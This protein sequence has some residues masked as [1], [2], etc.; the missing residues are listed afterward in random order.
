MGCGL[1]A[2]SGASGGR[3]CGDSRPWTGSWGGDRPRDSGLRPL[4]GDAHFLP[5]H[6]TFSSCHTSL[7]RPP[8]ARP[9]RRFFAS[10]GPAHHPFE[11]SRP[12]RT[13]LGHLG[14]SWGLWVSCSLC[15]PVSHS[16]PGF[17]RGSALCCSVGSDG[18][19]GLGQGSLHRS[20]HRAGLKS[21]KSPPILS[22][23]PWFLCQ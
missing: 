7:S 18:F 4:R 8:P 22:L 13:A 6:F 2:S 9:S 23:T 14:S 10:G 3:A 15:A 16:P 21:P 5:R 17:N 20:I 1:L 11:D 19:F 12:S